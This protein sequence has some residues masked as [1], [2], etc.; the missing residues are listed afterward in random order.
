MADVFGRVYNLHI[1][2][3]DLVIAQHTKKTG[4]EYQ[5]RLLPASTTS[6]YT[7]G[8]IDYLTIEQSITISNPLQIKATINYGGNSGQ[9]QMTTIEL[10]G[11]SDATKSAIIANKVLLLEVGYENQPTLPTLYVGHI[12]SVS[13]DRTTTYIRCKEG[14]N[15]IKTVNVYHK[16]KKTQTQEDV[17]KYLIKKF[18]EN[19][20][21]FGDIL[22]CARTDMKLGENR[23]INGTLISTITD[24]CNELDYVWFISKGK[25]YIRAKDL[26]RVVDL[27]TL[28]PKNIVG[29]IERADDKTAKPTDDK[30][31]KGVGIK[32]KLYMNAE[33]GMNT[34]IRIPFGEFEGDY[35]PKALSF[36]L[37]LDQ[38]PWQV[39]L[40]CVPVSTFDLQQL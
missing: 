22:T 19:G 7:D 35:K 12:E 30:S 37:N 10:R 4:Y 20:V 21:P 23:I 28:S 38:G 32:L 1:A 36:H 2:T 8:Y 5:G 24:F 6:I 29:N 39:S 31:N 17:F 3:T 9:D 15:V 18:G 26:D 34:Y 27:V 16:F 13:S 33:I 25:L 40:E 11:L 14:G